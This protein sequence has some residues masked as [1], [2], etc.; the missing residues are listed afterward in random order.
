LKIESKFI[1]GIDLLSANSSGK[2]DFSRKY[3]CE[4]NLNLVLISCGE[5][6]NEI[7]K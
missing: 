2:G 5:K 7:E 4:L 3:Q 6:Q 1:F